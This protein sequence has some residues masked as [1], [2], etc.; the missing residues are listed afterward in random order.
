MCVWTQIHT[1]DFCH[2]EA[3][4]SL[5]SNGRRDSPP[6]GHPSRNCIILHNKTILQRKVRV[7]SHVRT[8]HRPP[9]IQQSMPN[10]RVECNDQL[11]SAK[12]KT[13]SKGKLLSNRAPFY[14]IWQFS[15]L[16]NWL[17]GTFIVP[18]HTVASVM[19]CNTKRVS[20]SSFVL[21][22]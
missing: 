12:W 22:F 14:C 20:A 3:D 7:N 2:C 21:C 15:P 11:K 10:A 18:I 9:S 16:T 4:F 13:T 6:R 1:V 5:Q 8:I 17:Y 19:Y